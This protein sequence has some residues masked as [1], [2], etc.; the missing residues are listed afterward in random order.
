MAL[1]VVIYFFYHK[2]EVNILRIEYFQSQNNF[3]VNLF[4]LC[5][6][7]CLSFIK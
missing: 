5:K 7:N 1:K 6:K 4:I 2:G 3:E